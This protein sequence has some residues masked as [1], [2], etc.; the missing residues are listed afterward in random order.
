MYDPLTSIVEGESTLK[1]WRPA[2]RVIVTRVVGFMP[3]SFGDRLI[4]DIDRILAEGEGFVGFND[5]ELCEDY[6][7]VAR[8]RLTRWLAARLSAFESVSVLLGSRILSMGVSVAN[9]AL[10]GHLRSSTDRA[11]FEAELRRQGVQPPLT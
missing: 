4:S 7:A 2:P 9:I 6:D 11:W 3:E 10:R 1:L 8:K 5:W